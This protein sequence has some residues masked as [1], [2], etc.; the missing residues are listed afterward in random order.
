MPADDRRR[1]PAGHVRPRARPRTPRR[2]PQQPRTSSRSSKSPTVDGKKLEKDEAA[3]ASTVVV[4]PDADRVQCSLWIPI[5]GK[6]MDARRRRPLHLVDADR[7]GTNHTG[8]HLALTQRRDARPER[9]RPRSR[10]RPGATPPGTPPHVRHG[11]RRTRLRKTKKDA[12]LRRIFLSETWRL[13][14]GLTESGGCLGLVRR[15]V[16]GGMKQE[17]CR[18]PGPA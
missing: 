18:G 6:N 7:E 9:T 13:G 10:K 4:E 1:P 5:G 2:L 11:P 14:F 8:R 12:P 17:A 15:Q 16:S 3:P